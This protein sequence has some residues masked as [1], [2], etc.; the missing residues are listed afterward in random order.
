MERQRDRNRDRS[1]DEDRYI[2]R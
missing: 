2:R 1:D